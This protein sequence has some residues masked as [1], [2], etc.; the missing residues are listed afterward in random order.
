MPAAC[1][2]LDAAFRL[3]A[4][5]RWIVN[6]FHDG[7]PPMRAVGILAGAR[8]SLVLP[9]GGRFIGRSFVRIGLLSGFRWRFLKDLKPAV[10]GG[11]QSDAASFEVIGQS[12]PAVR[13]TLPTVS[14]L[15][16][17]HWLSLRSYGAKRA[18]LWSAHKDRI[19]RRSWR[20]R[21][22]PRSGFFQRQA[23]VALIV[24]GLARSTASNSLPRISVIT[25]FGFAEVLT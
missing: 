6:L 13:R 7:H 10:K 18:L 5:R 14:V 16:L 20:R 22:N 1:Q 21:L 11:E 25:P 15:D 2:M 17:A 24:Q 3:T 12:F 4:P 23:D 8:R 9:A 19:V